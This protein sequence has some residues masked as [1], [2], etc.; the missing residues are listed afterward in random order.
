MR[1]E[2]V[3]QMRVAYLHDFHKMEMHPHVSVDGGTGHKVPFN[4]DRDA[5]SLSRGQPAAIHPDVQG[6]YRISLIDRRSFYDP[7]RFS[8]RLT[9]AARAELRKLCEGDDLNAVHEHWLK[10]QLPSKYNEGPLYPYT[11]LKYHTLLVAA[12]LWNYI[13]NH[14]FD[15]LC[16]AISLSARVDPSTICLAGSSSLHL[17]PLSGLGRFDCGSKLGG[18]KPHPNFGDVWQRL[19]VNPPTPRHLD[20]A[21]RQIGEWS[22]ALQLVED[23]GQ[24][25]C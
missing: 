5:S 7:H 2:I 21:L 12:L 17:V 14:K 24:M 23:W 1:V 13:N 19:E 20:A 15:T 18:S 3:D 22:T 6:R 11:S 9:E 4:A 25:P 8:K 16:L 10:S